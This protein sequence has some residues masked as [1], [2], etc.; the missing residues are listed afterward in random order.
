M[1]KEVI[2]FIAGLLC[3]GLGIGILLVGAQVRS[4]NAAQLA[5][6][7]TDQAITTQTPPRPTAKQG[8]PV[9][10]TIP[11]LA[12][13]NPVIDGTYDH[14]T[15]QWTLTDD[16]VQFATATQPPN[17]DSGLTFMYGHNRRE[18]FTRLP[19]IKPGTLAYI[20]TDN[21]YVFTYRFTSSA[22]TQEYDTSIFS[23]SGK[24]VLVLQTCVGLFYENRQLFTFE[25][26]GVDRA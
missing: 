1:K 15:R 9:T 17:D 25:L 6:P 12:I 4:S 14:A 2:V 3:V 23:Y 10:L 8:K 21:G 26:T 24:P 11:D 13:S 7:V 22:V 20:T 19:R 18:V 16:K 5:Q